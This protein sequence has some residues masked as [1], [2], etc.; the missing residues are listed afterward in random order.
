MSKSK[1]EIRETFEHFD[2]DSNGTMDAVEFAA[3]LQAL[4]AAGGPEE[5]AAGLEALDSNRNGRI[6]F[7][8]FATWWGSR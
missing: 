6:D 7:N 8:E 2:R 3:L 4:G 5:L 1:E